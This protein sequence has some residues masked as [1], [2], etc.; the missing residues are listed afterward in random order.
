MG[1]EDTGINGSTTE[2]GGNRVAK[3]GGTKEF[4]LVGLGK[5]KKKGREGVFGNDVQKKQKQHGQ[6]NR[7]GG[8]KRGSHGKT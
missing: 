8:E 3:V 2:N 4:L 5:G 7:M 1:R 6:G